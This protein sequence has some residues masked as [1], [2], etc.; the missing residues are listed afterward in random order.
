MM[1]GMARPTRIRL[2]IRRVAVLV[3]AGLLV[4]AFGFVL[5]FGVHAIDA[6]AWSRCQELLPPAASGYHIDWERR[7]PPRYTCVYTD[8]RGLIVSERRP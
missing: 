8:P 3:A 2:I 6:R 7:F 1:S 5:L 4:G